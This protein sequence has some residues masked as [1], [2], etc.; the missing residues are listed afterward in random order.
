MKVLT[1]N[2][3]Y[4][5]GGPGSPQDRMKT[6]ANLV[7][8]HKVDVVCLQEAPGG[9]GNWLRYGMGDGVGSLAKLLG[10]QYASAVCWSNVACVA[11]YRIGVASRW[12]IAAKAEIT[13]A[14]R[15][16]VMV[17]VNNVN[18][19]SIHFDSQKDIPTQARALL[20]KIPKAQIIAGDFNTSDLDGALAPFKQAGFSPCPNLMKTHANGILDWI[21]SRGFS[22]IGS[23]T[24]I[25]SN[26]SDHLPVVGELEA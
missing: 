25:Q 1:C 6:L 19:A 24:V 26:I 7:R 13:V 21:F 2:F 4:V 12:P 22:G 9:A 14:G 15:K 3:G 10:W 11:D 20:S 5:D 16:H 18:V 8:Q 17:R 23:A